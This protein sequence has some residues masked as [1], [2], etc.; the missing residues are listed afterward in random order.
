MWLPVDRRSGRRAIAQRHDLL[1]AAADRVHELEPI[2]ADGRRRPRPRCPLPR[3][4]VTAR[5]P[6]GRTTRTSGGRSSSV[7]MKYSVSPGFFEAVAIG[8]RDAIRAVL[9]DFKV[10]D[11][12][13]GGVWRQARWPAAARER[14]TARRRLPF[15]AHANT[16]VGAG[17]RVDV[18][19]ILLDPRGHL[20]R[21]RKRG[22]RH[23]SAPPAAGARPAP[24]RPPIGPRLPRRDI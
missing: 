18:A 11:T 19:R 4:G 13:V 20:Q 1:G 10:S 8:E 9:D 16:H 23:R 24:R 22:T 5:S 2:D 3:G 7:R 12:S 14:H 21:G 15:S 17:G 6:A